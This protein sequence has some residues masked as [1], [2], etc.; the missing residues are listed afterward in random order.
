M[1]SAQNSCNW[2]K[3]F[4]KKW[5]NKW[6]SRIIANKQRQALTYPWLLQLYS[7]FMR[8]TVRFQNLKSS[9]NNIGGK[10]AGALVCGR[11]QT[12]LLSARGS[13][14]WAHLLR[15]CGGM[16]GHGR[17]KYAIAKVWWM[18]H[19]IHTMRSSCQMMSFFS[20]RLDRKNKEG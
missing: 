10:Y 2:S 18:E 9:G 1:W 13:T 16:H 3:P 14:F 6:E 4:Q 12:A 17:P 11:L 19:L 7:D 5:S 8:H 20:H 15:D